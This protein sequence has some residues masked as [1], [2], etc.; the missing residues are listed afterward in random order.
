MVPAYKI[1]NEPANI[2]PTEEKRIPNSSPR[3]K[4]DKMVKESVGTA[5]NRSTSRSAIIRLP[6][7]IG[8]HC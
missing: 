1:A 4:P 8:D 7:Q 5:M 3:K 6:T 2:S